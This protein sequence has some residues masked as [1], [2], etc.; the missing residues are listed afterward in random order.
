VPGV[1]LRP[2]H[3]AAHLMMNAADQ[4]Q[5]LDGDRFGDIAQL[6]VDMDAVAR[7]RLHDDVA[8]GS[9]EAGGLNRQPVHARRQRSRRE[10]PLFAGCLIARLPGAGVDDGDACARDRRAGGIGHRPGEASSGRLRVRAPH[11]GREASHHARKSEALDHAT[12][13][14]ADKQGVC[15]GSGRTS[16]RPRFSTDVSGRVAVL[17]DADL[18]VLVAANTGHTEQK[19]SVRPGERGGQRVDPEVGQFQRRPTHHT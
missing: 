17:P 1:D 7:S 4:R 9:L 12:Q 16:A 2:R 19:R 10:E 11:G 14:V 3:H 15:E 18:Y 5:R 6:Q 13:I 8:F